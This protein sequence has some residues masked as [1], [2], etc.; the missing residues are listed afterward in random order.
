MRIKKNK[1]KVFFSS[2]FVFTLLAFSN[3]NVKASGV[4]NCNNDGLSTD[5]EA[6]F[7]F[8]DY[9][10]PLPVLG[11][12]TFENLSSGA[13]TSLSW[14]FGDG[15][16]YSVLENS[17]THFY[18]ESGSYEVSLS[19]WSSDTQQCFSTISTI[20]E[21]WISD[22]P[23]DQLDCVWPGD[24][25]ADGVANLEDILNIGLEFGISGP[26]RDTVCG[27]WYG[28]L[29][30]DWDDWSTDG[31]DLKHSDCNG[32][33]IINLSDLPFT[34]NVDNSYTRLENGISVAESNGPPIKLQFNVD[35]V[36][37]TDASEIT[38]I[39]AGLMF[40]SSNV[41]MED[42]Y[43]VV[44]YLNFPGQYIDSSS[45]IIVDYDANSFFGGSG[46]VI[47]RAVDLTE[48]DQL[49]FGIA[50]KDGENTGGYGRIA[51][52]S[53]IID[54]DIID[55]RDE[56]E[57]Q[58]FNV[59]IKVVKVIDKF[60]N[61]LEISLSPEPA[62]VFFVNN[63]ITKVVDPVLSDKVK[64]FPNPVS[65]ILNINLGELNG[66]VLELYDV[67]G[68]RVIYRDIESESVL[69]LNVNNF[70]KG[71]YLL[72]IQTDQGIVSKRVV[73]K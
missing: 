29:A 57:G 69:E 23:C 3:V 68:K 50:R 38:T 62:S 36:Y 21:V 42:V 56:F 32:D 40:G 53:F 71:I 48:Q 72:K 35:T 59:D 7:S 20:V 12:I 19:V 26:P 25:N 5:C 51:T 17:V 4:E 22:D 11:G 39:T 52:V 15:S 41:P 45:Q 34:S 54:A 13:Y 64:V 9:D 63:I 10:G 44:L 73:V 66:Q 14:D 24:T 8:G 70:E 65:D 27:G 58:S 1:L 67:L 55:G 60:G 49:D 43:G 6:D 37:I 18:S 28:H 46:E 61:E 33:G 2:L 47:P 31:V 30:A 16:Y